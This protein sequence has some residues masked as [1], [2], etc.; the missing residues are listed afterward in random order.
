MCQPR[1]DKHKGRWELGTPCGSSPFAIK[2]TGAA[3]DETMATQPRHSRLCAHVERK[4]ENR[5][6]AQK[7]KKTTPNEVGMVHQTQGETAYA[8]GHLHISF[9]RNFCVG[10]PSE[11]QFGL[12]T[13]CCLVAAN[14][15]WLSHA[16]LFTGNA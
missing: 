4:N 14:S 7:K 1:G 16:V 3:S 15:A 2:D 8:F 12:A 9:G 6:F 5:Q 11:K 10:M 13:H